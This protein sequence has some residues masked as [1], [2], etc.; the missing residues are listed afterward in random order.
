MKS[1]KILHLSD[2]HI[3]RDDSL[4][5]DLPYKI[6]Q[7]IDDNKEKFSSEIN[8]ILVTG[9]IFDGKSEFDEALLKKATTFFDELINALNDTLKN[10]LKR[11]D[12]IFTPG[13][14]DVIRRD[15]DI[16]KK[17]ES[18]LIDF[19]GED[20]HRKNYGEDQTTVKVYNDYKLIIVGFNSVNIDK[21]KKNQDYTNWIKN[22]VLSK[23]NVPDNDL[24]ELAN[25]II[26]KVSEDKEEWDDYGKIPLKQISSISTKIK[27][28][29]PNYHEF[30]IIGAF[31]H[32]FYPFPETLIKNEDRSIIRNYADIIAQFQSM[33]I[34]IILH[35]H[36]H[37]PVQRMITDNKY[38]KDPSKG[39][40]V[41]S[42]GSIGKDD[43][44]NK[45]FQIIEVFPNK[46][47]TKANVYNFEY[48]G[49]EFK[50]VDLISV[51]PNQKSEN[52]NSILLLDEFE[53]RNKSDFEKY[54]T[55]IKDFDSISNKYNIDTIIKFIG[56]C[57]T[58]FSKTKEL[59]NDT[60]KMYHLI[61][62]VIHYRVV[63]LDK[64]RNKETN[65]HND[66]LT[67]I[68]HQLKETLASDSN[69]AKKVLQF[70][71]SNLMLESIEKYNEMINENKYE[72]KL[73]SGFIT[74]TQF[75]TDLYLALSS[76]GDFFYI[77]EGI[78][79][80]INIKMEEDCIKSK[81]PPNS[82]L[83]KSDTDR[84]MTL[85]EFK[86][87]DPTAH[88]VAVLIVKYFEEKLNFFEETIKEIGVKLYYITSNVIKHNYDLEN[89]NFEAYIPKLLPLLI[90]DNLYKE[91][92]VFIRELIQ[93]SVD[94]ILLRRKIENT[95]IENHFI[96]IE[97]GEEKEEDL[98]DNNR[99]VKKHFIKIT[100]NGIGM[101]TYKIERYLTSIGRSFYTSEEFDD[102]QKEK[103]I[104]YNPISNFGIGF[105]SVFLVA[106]EVRIKTKYFNEVNPKNQNHGI[107]V[108]IP[109]YEGCFFINNL[110]ENCINGTE[111]TLYLKEENNDIESSIISYIKETILDI[112]I[113][114]K[115]IKKSGKATVIPPHSLRTDFDKNNTNPIFKLEIENGTVKKLE[116]NFCK[117]IIF[118]EFFPKK[119]KNLNLNDGI[120]MKETSNSFFE[121]EYAT[122][123]V[124]YP[125][126]AIQLDVSREKIISYKKNK[127]N[128]KY[129]FNPLK[130]NE[131]KQ[132]ILQEFKK[133]FSK[134]LDEI[135]KNKKTSISNMKVNYIN[136]FFELNS[137]DTSDL[138]DKFLK[139]YIIFYDDNIKLQLTYEQINP[140]LNY[141][142]VSEKP[143][144]N[145]LIN[146]RNRE[147]I[148]NST[149]RLSSEKIKYATFKKYTVSNNVNIL[150]I[151]IKMLI[152]ELAVSLENFTKIKIHGLREKLEKKLKIKFKILNEDFL[153]KNV[154]IGKLDQYLYRN[155]DN[156]KNIYRN[157]NNN[158]YIN[159]YKDLNKDLYRELERD[160]ERDLY[161][162]L[163][164]NLDINLERS[165]DK[166]VYIGIDR[167]LD[168]YLHILSKIN[169]EVI[170]KEA[171][172]EVLKEN[173][174]ECNI[175]LIQN[176]FKLNTEHIILKIKIHFLLTELFLKNKKSI[177]SK[178]T[179][180]ENIDLSILNNFHL[181][182]LDISNV[183]S[184][185]R[186]FNLEIEI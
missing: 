37:S 139:M 29:V 7:D 33:N 94:A 106:D 124:N 21:N 158:L 68:E 167:D 47:T 77:E 134:L 164:R 136:R 79:N 156:L 86:S 157:V 95:P 123:V 92:A 143:N 104:T 45:S 88:K 83:L 152:T 120:L 154:S 178:K 150:E 84:R 186:D 146:K 38:F 69:Y 137:C 64:K 183:L 174:E 101:D 125:S 182:Y 42:A 111:I 72:E 100:D 41:F 184:Y 138:S 122:V 76:Y 36:K 108:Y 114:I 66:I 59:L 151:L 173:L 133:Q 175:S 63:F 46:N 102:L 96:T 118:L 85:V 12:F 57:I 10:K 14:H 105:L 165:L 147:F 81:I 44:T 78:K 60:P 161:R 28:L 142:C 82:I 30:T 48:N 90:G 116:N 58:K 43:V 103:N 171:F 5:E 71:K 180:E 107:E 4:I 176:E 65:Y 24:N 16:Y 80:K 155:L 177:Y 166:T 163:Y 153:D 99:N 8:T 121:N 135:N 11:E 109:N 169:L 34:K 126:D 141:I 115:I 113:P 119:L 93:N 98:K 75:F 144:S 53:N 179:D 61:L 2:I 56:N 132:V 54:Q 50:G 159:L 74:I 3:G 181:I 15:K 172:E 131:L 73:Y 70:L 117:N 6:K 168:K 148:K 26:Q 149:K 19:Y 13:N 23:V 112:E 32:H 9:D 27:E 1:L 49:R 129:V 160:L 25:S 89:Q 40:F 110:K 22:E 130:D 128:D 127:S 140:N 185:N 39:I 62:L 52:S 67:R 20:Y 17:Y 31:H 97:F 145:L 91:K 162:N 55:T 87:Y 51:P 18:F 170:L 35:G